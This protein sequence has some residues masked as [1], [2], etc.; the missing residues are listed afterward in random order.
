M[1]VA[2]LPVDVDC[3]SDGPLSDAGDPLTAGRSRGEAAVAP[4]PAEDLL[5]SESG[6]SP[7]STMNRSGAA[8]MEAHSPSDT[9]R[10]TLDESVFTKSSV[11]DPALNRPRT[12][13]MH[14][15]PAPVSGDAVRSTATSSDSSSRTRLAT[16]RPGIYP[17]LQD[18][19]NMYDTSSQ[20]PMDVDLNHNHDQGQSDGYRNL[21]EQGQMPSPPPPQQHT[22]QGFQSFAQ[23][24]TQ[25]PSNP[26]AL[27]QHLM[28]DSCPHSST[29][30]CLLTS[31]SRL[32]PPDYS[33]SARTCR[34]YLP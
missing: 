22:T 13:D 4:R 24:E 15:A 32:F 31:R 14:L 9:L 6:A 5:P 10:S 29:A 33:N 3:S 8:P 17:A 34:Q 23:F 16:Q 21:P 20:L 1:P 27:N 28:L 11:M 30:I 26:S 12:H 25:S 7:A 2:R 18:G 19:L